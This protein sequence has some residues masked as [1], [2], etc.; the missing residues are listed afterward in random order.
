MVFG[1]FKE[2]HKICKAVN[3]SS[4]LPKSKTQ[5]FLKV[6]TGT[7]L[8]QLQYFVQ[9]GADRLLSYFVMRIPDNLQ[10][11]NIIDYMSEK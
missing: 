9:N 8:P 6:G 4:S 10:V 2:F 11:Q 5:R 3:A 1:F 7:E